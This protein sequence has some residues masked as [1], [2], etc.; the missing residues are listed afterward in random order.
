MCGGANHVNRVMT[1]HLA[2]SQTTRQTTPIKEAKAVSRQLTPWMPF[3]LDNVWNDIT[4]GFTQMIDGE[5]RTSMPAIDIERKNNAVIVRADLPGVEPDEVKIEV[6]DGV[7]TISG[8]REEQTEKKEKTYV[9]HERRYGSF[10]RSIAL[11]DGVDPSEI[12]AT[13]SNGVLE[14]TI[15]LPEESKKE[16][17]AITP[18]AG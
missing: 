13:T 3:E 2:Q 8:E 16:A 17:V 1:T 5:K 14:I 4:R 10:M 6:Q 15:P 12:K 11:P 18:T 9:R 7:L